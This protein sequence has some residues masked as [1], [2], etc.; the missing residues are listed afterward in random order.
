MFIYQF[1]IILLLKLGLGF[2]VTQESRCEFDSY[3]R[4]VSGLIGYIYCIQGNYFSENCLRGFNPNSQCIYGYDVIACAE[5]EFI[6]T[7]TNIYC[8]YIYSSTRLVCTPSGM[9]N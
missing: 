9:K 1:G 7:Y 6:F 4:S 3:S 5:S 2:G 8:I